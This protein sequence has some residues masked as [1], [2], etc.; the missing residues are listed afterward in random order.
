MNR[1]ENIIGTTRTAGAVAALIVFASAFTVYMPALSGEFLAWDDVALIVE[2]NDLRQ[3]LGLELFKWA[4]TTAFL[5]VWTPL[6]LVSFAVDYRLWGLNPWGFHL[7]NNVLHALNSLL[8]FAV[9]RRLVM[10]GYGRDDAPARARALVTAFVAGL[11]FALHP[12]HVESV[13]W[14]AERK[15]V[16]FAFFYLL[17]LLCYARYAAAESK[18]IVFY[19][20]AVV[21]AFASASSKPMAVTFP[22]VLLVLDFFPFRRM[23]GRFDWRRA[24][25]VLVDKLPFAAVSLFATI[26]MFEVNRGGGV[27][28]A[29]IRVPV[30]KTA[31]TAIAGYVFYL[32]KFIWPVDLLPLY[33]HLLWNKS[34]FI[35][36]V[37]GVVILAAVSAYAIASVRKRPYVAAAWFF[38]C[39]TLLPTA[40]MHFAADRYAYISIAAPALLLGL[41]ASTAVGR[42]APVKAAS[43]AVALATLAAL[44]SLTVRQSRIWH[45]D[46]SLWDYQLTTFRSAFYGGHS[47]ALVNRANAYMKRGRLKEALADFNLAVSKNPTDEK[48]WFGR[49]VVHLMNG[50]GEAA[51]NDLTKAV[52]LNPKY[53]EAYSQRGLIL[54]RLKNDAAGALRDFD[55]AVEIDPRPAAHWF[56]KA[57]ALAI[58]GDF[59]RAELDFGRAL[60]LA[61][62]N[63]RAYFNRGDV[64][65]AMGDYSGAEADFSSALRL[66]PNNAA[67]MAGR[68]DVNALL[69][70]YAEAAADYEAAL[71][72][73]P[74]DKETRA[75]LARINLKLGRGK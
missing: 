2:N 73:S 35:G 72:R 8:V 28:K 21:F 46:L 56:N 15:D 50:N 4:Y 33:P 66:D 14:I 49:G 55:R 57:S 60:E 36:G 48:A 47:I 5:K 12:I 11:I 1:N 40:A 71:V 17:G 70:R 20:L 42:P 32:Y 62:G 51:L 65:A 63:A 59:N 6:T 37:G 24:A 7:T 30:D 68:G 69:G 34:F 43:I 16:L 52:E 67:A 3:G 18:R 31:L 13:A 45:D 61:P 54:L 75:R 9:S 27:F 26:V 58:L 38:Y 10:L 64:R 19:S 44:S 39:A 53:D 25:S 41:L 74:Y 22:L 23:A 29:A